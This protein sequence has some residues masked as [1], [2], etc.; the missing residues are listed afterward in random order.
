MVSGYPDTG[1]THVTSGLGCARVTYG[2]YVYGQIGH[3]WLR[4]EDIQVLETP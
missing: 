1:S 4:H 2:R 3:E